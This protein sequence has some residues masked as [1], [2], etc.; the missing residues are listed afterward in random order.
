MK[1]RLLADG[2]EVGKLVAKPRGPSAAHTARTNC[3]R[4][5]RF[6]STVP[7]CDIADRT[8]S[9]KGIPCLSAT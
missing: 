8:A 3:K 9:I 1:D 5:E 2:D 7:R 6:V 4:N